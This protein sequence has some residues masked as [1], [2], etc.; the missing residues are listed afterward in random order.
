MYPQTLR[1]AKRA[2]A[3]F[4]FLLAGFSQASL[5]MADSAVSE[6]QVRVFYPKGKCETGWIDVEVYARDAG[7]WLP[8]PDHPRVAT[9]TCELE[10]PGILLQEIRVRC[11]DPANRARVS[12]WR[13]GA[14]VFK[15]LS[16]EQCPDE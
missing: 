6:E 13:V 14:E 4:F 10:D 8:H 2:G 1:G 15:P 7:I 16:A 3:C 11:A 12:N 9:D 5:A